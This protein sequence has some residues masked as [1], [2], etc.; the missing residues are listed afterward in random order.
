MGEMMDVDIEKVMNGEPVKVYAFQNI[1]Y[2]WLHVSV[3]SDASED[4]V[5]I[6]EAEVIFNLVDSDK[7]IQDAAEMLDKKI[8]ETYAEAEVKVNQ[9]K[10]QKARL[11]S[12]T[13]SKE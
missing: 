6:G 10:D 12:L 7:A 3:Y 11:L 2:G 13:H 1:N 8:Q 9:I 4:Y 5:C